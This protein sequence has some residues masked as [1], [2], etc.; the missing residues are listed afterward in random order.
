MP[1]AQIASIPRY[2]TKFSNFGGFSAYP[3]THQSK[4]WHA[5]VYA[6]CTRLCIFHLD[7]RIV[8]PLGGRKTPNLTVFSTQHSVLTPPG[9]IEKN[10]NAI[11]HPPTFPHP[12]ISR[13]PFL[14]SNGLMAKWRSHTLPFKPWRTKINKKMTNVEL[15]RPRR[16][17][18]SEPHQTR[19]S[20]SFVYSETFSDPMYS[21]AAGLS[22]RICRNAPQF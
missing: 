22:L 6:R 8:S 3:F 11:A 2:L 1:D 16:P 5:R 19:H 21:F 15:V 4:N 10:L 9:N 20:V 7:Q 18:K 13:P 17:A 14:T 12:M